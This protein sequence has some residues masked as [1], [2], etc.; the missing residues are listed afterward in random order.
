MG[1]LDRFRSKPKK[2]SQLQK[3]LDGNLEKEAR[4]PV[5]DMAPAMGS[6][7]PMRIDPP[8]N[9]HHL[10][11]LSINYSHLQT[12]ITRIASQTIAKGYRLEQTVESPSEDQKILLEKLNLK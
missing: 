8:Y 10:E 7:G 11:D 12:V 9:L 1:L 3:Y 2:S 4:T 5:Y 6:T